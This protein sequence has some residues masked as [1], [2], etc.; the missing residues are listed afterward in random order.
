MGS[1]SI[2]TGVVFLVAALLGTTSGDPGPVAASEDTPVVHWTRTA[3]GVYENTHLFGGVEEFEIL[4]LPNIEDRS[5]LSPQSTD[6]FIVIV[7]EAPEASTQPDPVGIVMLVLTLSLVGV[8]VLA[9]TRGKRRD[10]KRAIPQDS[11]WNP[12]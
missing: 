8:L 12:P 11:W 5:A 2:S 9:A 6:T 10:P 4:V 1:I 7:E 3:P